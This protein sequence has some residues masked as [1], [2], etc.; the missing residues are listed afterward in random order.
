[1]T[2]PLT[3]ILITVKA[4]EPKK[5]LTAI[6]KILGLFANTLTVR[7]MYSLLNKDKLTKSIQNKL[8]PTKKNFFSIFFFIF[9]I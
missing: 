4:I 5:V 8:Y 2:L 6:C 3:Y 1:M 7:D 9:E